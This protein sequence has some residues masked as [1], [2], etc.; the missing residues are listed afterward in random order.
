MYEPYKIHTTFFNREY[1]PIMFDLE[2]DGIQITVN[3]AMVIM[4]EVL[5]AGKDDYI[6]HITIIASYAQ[7]LFTITV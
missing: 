6:I 3:Q 5:I 1:R 7:I 2:S 4:Q